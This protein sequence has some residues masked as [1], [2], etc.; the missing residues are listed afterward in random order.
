VDGAA[1]ISSIN[2]DGGTID[3]VSIGA[4]TAAT[5]LNVNGTI[6]L[7]GNYPVGTNNVAVGYQAAL[8]TTT[9][10]NSTAIG[11]CALR[12]NTTGSINTAVGNQAMLC[13]TT[14]EEN[15]AVGNVALCSNTTGCYNTAV[16]RSAAVANTTGAFNVAI[17][18]EALRENQ[19][20]DQSVAIGQSALRNQNPVGNAD[21]NNVAVGFQAALCTTTGRLN[22]SVGAC[23]LRLNTTACNN[24][25]FGF[26]AMRDNET[27]SDNTASGVNALLCNTTGSNNTAS[28]CAALRD[29]T[30]G[31]ANTAFG[32][33]ALLSNTT[34]SANSAFACDALRC[35]TTGTLNTAMGVNALCANVEGDQS[36]AIGTDALRAQNPVGNV[37]MNNTALG[38]RAGCAITTGTNL[39]VI[40]ATAAAS[41]ATATNEITLGNSSVTC[42]RV[43]GVGFETSTTGTVFNE[44][45]N[46]ADFRIESDTDPNAFF[47]EGSSG[48]VGIGTSSPDSARKL[49][50]YTA[51]GGFS[52][53]GLFETAVTSSSIAFKD[54]SNNSTSAV[55]IG[56]SGNNLLHYTGGS[57][58]MRIDSSGNVLVGKTAGST[59]T[60]GG[61]LLPTGKAWFVADGTD[62][63]FLNRLTSDGDIADFAK[64]GTIVG[65][66]GSNSSLRLTMGNADV[67]LIY[68]TDGT[69]Y[70]GP[71]SMTAVGGRDNAINLGFPTNRFKDLYLS[72]NAYVGDKIIHDGDTNTAIR[73]P[74]ADT[75]TVET[76]GSE[77]VR[78]DSSG[79]L[80][81]GGTTAGTAS[82][83][84]LVLVNGTAPTG[85]VTDGITLYAEDVSSSSELKVRDEA[86]NVTTLSP[87]NF[88]LIPEGPSEEMAWSY[89]SERD[90]KRI[91]VDMLKA[92]R[93][94]EQL[95]GEKLV[96]MA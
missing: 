71:Y 26:S 38:F 32:F 70:I 84:N 61:Q 69:D 37:D 25:A 64:D 87:H 53:S 96:H 28:G 80:L 19:E 95:T 94:L 91:N 41:A 88:D 62:P 23:S 24:T 86:G 76:A 40:G 49:H 79:N 81:I 9:G 46:D 45:G 59:S 18:R 58:R 10:C 2:V 35:N 16:G 47:L 14:G 56:S 74:A 42:L 82:A 21:M 66:I 67:G 65:S 83:G 72:G 13:N 73:F 8:C 90:G 30:T 6:K 7:D 57:E 48:N 85:N 33:R 54:T 68:Q 93:L 89:Y 75:V 63:L 5:S 92:I 51:S 22:T 17:G 15:V 12:L 3:G 55:R 27:G 36:V 77:R 78:I 50:V 11:A 31:A 4:S 29:N 20:G 1:A 44:A 60:V 34:A 43:P 52:I 39:T